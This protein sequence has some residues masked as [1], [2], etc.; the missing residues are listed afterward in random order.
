M[1]RPTAA[2]LLDRLREIHQELTGEPLSD[3]TLAGQ[4]PITLSTFNRWK[5]KD[6]KMFRAI[7]KMLDEAGWLVEEEPTRRPSG[8]AVAIKPALAEVRFAILSLERLEALL[9]E[10]TEPPQDGEVSA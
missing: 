10:Q 5:K 9:R 3:E 2:Q 4:L 6:T 7:V 1:S 8:E